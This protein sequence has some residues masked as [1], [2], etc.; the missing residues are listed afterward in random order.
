MID[1]SKFVIISNKNWRQ[2]AAT[3]QGG[4]FPHEE[5]VPILQGSCGYKGWQD[6]MRPH[7]FKGPKPVQE[8]I[9][10]SEWADRIRAGQGSNV[11][12]AMLAA[13]VKSKDQMNLNYCWVFGSVRAVE[14]RRLMLGLPHVEKSP[15]SVGGPATGWRNVGGYAGQAFDQLQSGG[16]CDASFLDK[17][18]S[19]TPSRWKKGWEANAR[20]CEVV[21]WYNMD[22]SD[23]GP[24]YDEVITC[25]L[26][27]YP[28][29]AGLGWWGH[30]V[31]FIGAVLLPDSTV[32][33]LFQNSW[34]QG[35]WPRVG[36]NGFAILTE[37]RATPDGAAA[38]IFSN[39][40]ACPA[41]IKESKSCPCPTLPP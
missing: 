21:D 38:P 33:I 32:G 5:L 29:A 20:D 3:Y 31:A 28:V 15:E 10:R 39:D 2:Y 30:L 17:P 12:Q 35:D 14:A 41:T 37:S 25:L 26:N 16:A 1:P 8:I 13:G 6:P 23:G 36:D 22:G 27:D 18:C 40:W 11:Y 7:E 19:L 34:L 24:M 9:P 4:I